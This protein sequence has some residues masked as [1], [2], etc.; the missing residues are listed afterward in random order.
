MFS[1]RWSML[2][3]CVCEMLKKN[4]NSANRRTECALQNEAK[5]FGKGL[6]DKRQKDFLES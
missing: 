5:D 2:E 3:Q 1:V 6:E 4:N